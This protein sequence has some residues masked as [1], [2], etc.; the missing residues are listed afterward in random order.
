MEGAVSSRLRSQGSSVGSNMADEAHEEKCRNQSSKATKTKGE[1]TDKCKTQV[2]KDASNE[3]DKTAKTTSK[4]KASSVTAST[5]NINKSLP[6]MPS[7]N[8]GFVAGRVDQINATPDSTPVPN[9]PKTQSKIKMLSMKNGQLLL[10]EDDTVDQACMQANNHDE[11]RSQKSITNSVDCPSDDESQEEETEQNLATILQ[12]LTNTVKKLEKS[13]RKMNVDQKRQDNKV[14]AMDSLQSQQATTLRGIVDKLDDQDDKIEMLIGIVARQDLQIQALTHKMDASYVRDN[15]LNI[16]I[17]GM[18]ETQG[19]NCF[20]EVANFF[21]NVLKIDKAITLVQANRIGVGSAGPMLVK[22]RSMDDK[23]LIYKN[24]SKLKQINKGRARP[25]FI[26][27]QLPESWA[28]NRRFNHYVKLQNQKLPSA[29]QTS[30][31][32][33]KGKLHL[34][35]VPYEPPIKIKS[36]HEL[37]HIAPER[38]QMLCNLQFVEGSRE[39]QDSSIFT[40]FAAEIYSAQQVQ[41]YYDALRLF[42]P[43]ATH[44]VCAYKLPGTN[45]ATS[46]GAIDDG[47]YGGSRVL[48]GLL[49][50]GKHVN[51][52]LF[53][54]QIYGGQHIGALRFQLMEKVAQVALDNLCKEQRLA[55]QPLTDQQ[56]Q[57]LNEEIRQQ[58]LAKL[59]KQQEMKNNPWYD[60]TDH[61]EQ[62]QISQSE[63]D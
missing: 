52:A 14:S 4:V 10:Q 31:E 21:K 11:N 44:I 27:D 41:N 35:N 29:Q 46:F 54:M 5:S 45:L 51:K 59:Q 37:C 3:G 32:V 39:T 50:K 63:T 36:V 8:R 55:R 22:V 19:K 17:S 16:L 53:V 23:S 34:N 1:N 60:A 49:N 25:Y 18:A 48:L 30:T 2:V 62:S 9:T 7:I 33:T 13:I 26:A 28:E 20:H 6:N 61:E 47:E 40:G 58:E 43:E 15:K 24:V 57:E 12:E 42:H 38:K 56:L